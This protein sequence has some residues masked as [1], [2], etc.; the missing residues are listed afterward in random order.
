MT[1]TPLTQAQVL[2]EEYVALEPDWAADLAKVAPGG[3]VPEGGFPALLKQVH[4]KQDAEPL[5]ALCFS[6]GGIRSAT[7]N[8]GVLQGLAERGVLGA[9]HYLS[10]V[11]GGGYVSSWFVGWLR[12]KQLSLAGGRPEDVTPAVAK[13]AFKEVVA[14]IKGPQPDPRRP[15][16]TPIRHLRAYSNYLTPRLGLLSADTWTTGV[17]VARNLLLNWLVLLPLL[18]GVLV[19][20]LLAVAT[21][22]T[23][24]NPARAFGWALGLAG[25]GL[26]LMTALRGNVPT[27]PGEDAPHRWL[28]P[29][30]LVLFLA[31]VGSVTVAA[32]YWRG[33]PTDF[34]AAFRVAWW[35]SA[36]WA[37][38]LPLAAYL[39]GCLVQWIA[40]PRAPRAVLMDSL[41]LL[42]AGLVEAA[43]C[44]ALVAGLLWPLQAQEPRP[45]LHA[46]LAP[47]LVLGPFLLGKTL[48]VALASF[49]ETF[50]MAGFRRDSEYGDAQREWWARWS[51][52]L[53]IAL[54]TWLA[55]SALVYYSPTV[56][57]AGW[58]KL[59][60]FVTGS[61]LG[62]AISL[63][64]KSG[65]TPG[66]EDEQCASPW[67][68]RLVTWG[69]P[70]FCLLLLAGVAY[71]AQALLAFAGERIDPGLL[72]TMAKGDPLIAD[73]WFVLGGAIGL[74]ALGMFMAFF[75]N[76]NRFSLQALYRN[77]LVRAYLG[78]S[79]TGR[80]PNFFTGFD[81]E[82]NLRLRDLRHVRPL[83]VVNMALNLVNGG[84]LAWQERKAESFTA[85][86]LHC[87]SADLAYRSTEKYGGTHGISLGTAVATSGAAANPNMGYNSSPAVGFVM[88]LFNARLGTWLGNPARSR[89][90]K[91]GPRLSSWFYLLAEAFGW[92]NDRR[93]YV[94]L[95]DGGHFD[96]LGLYEMVRRRCRYIVVSDASQDGECRFD[97]LGNAIRKIRIDLGISID[98]PDDI[99]IRPK[100][101][102]LTERLVYCAK[103]RINYADVDG[104]GVAAGTLL[105]VKP[106][107]LEKEPY[108]IYNYARS[109]KGFPHETTVDQWFSETQ[110]ESY[111]AL[112]KTAILRILGDAAIADVAGIVAAVDAHLAG[113]PAA[114]GADAADRL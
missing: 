31:G 54:V 71:G 41:V 62:T 112:G 74:F 91:A 79:N 109:S 99:R 35:P 64:G 28:A 81:P 32:Y 16:P 69:V 55:G 12:R 88:T 46:V 3:T 52:W 48:F 26:V 113:P 102:A 45:A 94:N 23:S 58:A 40:F 75:V 18:A 63:V 34:G 114:A 73:P 59:A 33:L 43:I 105:Y 89:Y 106:T 44:A 66:A 97:D 4:A 70:L 110:F 83:P 93:A 100:S 82:D 92:T 25:S 2:Y 36:A 101:A 98:F 61:G 7:F 22:P 67:S 24:G 6:G 11:S 38:A 78:A 76:V 108:D 95:S 107:L 39:G 17:I 56:L 80:T 90:T 65:K 21:W 37:A 19:L 42:G 86:P 57:R 111:R 27:R 30:A 103:G 9:F 14:E 72:G 60:T 84:N 104:A 8:L 5:A 85:T 96:N 47:A 10:S 68:Q 1:P 15:E 20:P 53:L 51:A 87:G 29:I 50:E 77:R 13:A 49:A